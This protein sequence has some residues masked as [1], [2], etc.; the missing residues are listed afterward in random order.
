MAAGMMPAPPP[1]DPALVEAVRN[2]RW[3]EVRTMVARAPRPLPPLVALLAARA[4]RMMGEPAR[5]L[6]VLRPAISLAGALDA[7][8]RLEAAAAALALN[9]DPWPYLSPLVRAA[10]SSAQRR[11]AAAVLRSAWET[12]PLPALHR[13]PRR[14]LPYSL[15]R[16]LASTIAIRSGDTT[17]AA[18]LLADRVG[19]EPALRTARW[20]TTREGLP[21]A[22]RL[23]V[24]EALLAGGDWREADRMLSS[25]G[26]P[27]ESPLR[28]RLA[29]L[30]GRT[31]Y[32][33]GNYA[34]AAESFDLARA[35]AR[36][37]VDLF[38]A[39]VQRARIAE[40]DGELAAAVPLFDRARDAQPRE[41]EGWDGG[42]RDRVA[43]GRAD[44]AVALLARCPA[45]VLKVSGPR[46]A[47]A[48]LLR[49]DPA[50]ARAVLARIPEGVPV[51]RV[52]KVALHL[53]RG[54]SDTARAEA[55]GVLADPRAGAWRDGVTELL[56]AAEGPGTIAPTRELAALARLAAYRGAPSA[57]QA[58][59]RALSADP[60]WAKVLSGELVEPTDWNGP[61]R[62]LA[63][64]GLGR[65]AARLY[66][67]A[68]PSASPD[69][70]AW[71]AR[72]LAL[73]GNPNAAL[74]AGERL[75]S[76]LGPLP[77]VLVPD[78]LLPS[79][80]PPAVVAR[81]VEAAVPAAVAPAWLAAIVRQESRFDPDTYSPAGA[82]GV[83]QMV[84]EA[85]RA[86]GGAPD[87][88]R[89]G[90]RA[91]FL[92]AREVG[93]LT[94]RFGPRLALV[95]SAYNAG[96]TVVT[97]WLTMLGGEAQGVVFTAAIPYRET[98]GYVV[99][100]REGVELARYLSNETG[101]RK[102]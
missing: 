8:L 19:D 86:L 17:A 9:Q 24:G 79:I 81:C 97:T 31:A 78:Q 2:G 40:I 10:A 63:E 99:A 75:W 43:L 38:T 82:I 89:D 96:E 42:M 100:V 46:L 58:L 53:Q 57:R 44:E 94:A 6:E 4:T 54:E 18:R 102:E 69:E 50:R 98:S 72:T 93:R 49:G 61:A 80:L 26:D 73:W 28:W 21:T 51:A 88:L 20:L 83:A 15:L 47:A 71:S 16:Q 36:S 92:A 70:L 25:A 56:P 66:P 77:A 45:P 34:Q 22:S 101:P 41:V 74:S 90:Q 91:L 5:A 64:V 32:R 59:A 23:T 39:T 62:Q 87:D 84:P 30:R 95:A 11:A 55:A 35:V 12:L 7:V 13:V 60:A 37:D 3:A 27:P 29:F 85:A 48:L 1:P 68:F 52:L 33:L 76:R 14:A 65:D 67:D